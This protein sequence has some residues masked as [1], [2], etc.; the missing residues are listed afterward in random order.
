MPSRGTPPCSRFPLPFVV[1][2]ASP[3]RSSTALAVPLQAQETAADTA[4]AAAPAAPKEP[5]PLW[6]IGLVGI[7]ALPAG[8]SG[9]RPEPRA[10]ARAAVRHLPRLA[11][12]RRRQRHRPAR[13]SSTPRFEWD[14]SGVGLVRLVGQQGACARRHAVHRHA[15]GD[16]AGAQG[17]PRR[18][19]RRR[20]RPPPDAAGDPGPRGV[21]RQRQLRASRLDLRA[22]PVAHRVDG[23]QLRAGGLGQRAVRRPHA[24]PPV[25]R[26]RRALR[27]APTARPTT[28]A[29]AWSPRA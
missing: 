14:V 7:A 3:R 25:L 12:A 9:L 26:R 13:R 20:A 16:R 6:E 27:D 15:G 24:Q 8:V 28:P 21:R 10:R 2:W 5:L 18:P 17:Q 19:G 11:A 4:G 23:Q 1:R 29:P 22:A